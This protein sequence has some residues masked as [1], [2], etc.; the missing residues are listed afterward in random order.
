MWACF[1]QHQTWLNAA[2]K[3]RSYS[4]LWKQTCAHF[5][6]YF[7]QRQ[8]TEPIL[9]QLK[10]YSLFSKKTSQECK[11]ALTSQY[12]TLSLVFV[13][14]LFVLLSR[15]HSDHISEGSQV[16][17]VTLCVK[18]LKWHWPTELQRSGIELP[19][20]L[21]TE[22]SMGQNQ[23]PGIFNLVISGWGRGEL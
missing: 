19:G 4:W 6:F 9:Q 16:S 8:N 1:F 21:K 17:K 10:S 23:S 15:R 7:A 18:N 11:T 12:W 5:V 13:F 3:K 14:C 2:A 22:A 20:Q